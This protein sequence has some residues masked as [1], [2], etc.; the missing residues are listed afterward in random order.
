MTSIDPRAAITQIIFLRAHLRL[1]AAGMKHSQMTGRQLLDK[2][3]KLTGETYRRGAYTTA[4][5][6]LSILYRAELEKMNA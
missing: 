5:E 2:V 1:H 6:D 3:G 4:L